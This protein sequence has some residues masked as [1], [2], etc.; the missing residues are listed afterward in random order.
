MKKAKYKIVLLSDMKGD[1]PAKLKSAAS[2][3]KMINGEIMLFHVQNPAKI[4]KKENQLSAMRTINNEY[5]I[6]NKKIQNLL[7]SFSKDYGVNIN[8]SFAL[9]NIK[10]EIGDY[11]KKQEPDIVV[12]GKKKSQ[13]MQFIGDKITQFV[14]QQYK[15]P[16]LITVDENALDSE[17]AL[18]FGSLNDWESTRNLGFVEDLMK[19]TNKPLKSFKIVKNS[20]LLREPVDKKDEKVIEYVFEQNDN[21]IEKIPNYLAKNKIN[22]LFVK[23]G[24]KGQSQRTNLTSSDFNSIINKLNV[25]V[26]I[27]SE[28]NLV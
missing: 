16:I 1:I 14:L 19:H 12:L 25:P 11:I 23:R 26:M 21:T 24:R 18:S 17:E 20:D 28:N 5:T 2:L 13:S 10:T 27:S 7:K 15:G 4:V 8:Y 6:T 22:L 9:G 3:A